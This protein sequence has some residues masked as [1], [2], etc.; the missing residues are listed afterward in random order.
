L[1]F[2]LLN[3]LQYPHT[4]VSRWTFFEFH[5]RDLQDVTG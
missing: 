3:R 5:L 1:E 2:Y 4:V